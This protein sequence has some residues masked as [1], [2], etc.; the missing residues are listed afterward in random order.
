MGERRASGAMALPGL[1]GTPFAGWSKAKAALDKATV[2]ARKKAAKETGTIP[3][4]IVPWSIHDLR[5]TVATESV[6]QAD[7][8][9]P[10][11][12]DH[13]AP[14]H[15][16][17]RAA[18]SFRRHKLARFY[19]HFQDGSSRIDDQ[20]G[21]DL[22]SPDRAASEALM[23]ARQLMAEAIKFGTD[24]GFDAVVVADEQVVARVDIAGTLPKRLQACR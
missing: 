24:P 8:A 19:F 23:A 17:R 11:T 5:R 10:R 21:I 9:G 12:A 3:A 18:W 2:E 15:G 13:M 1:L 14:S 6:V 7:S 4:S 20:E 16:R 22:P